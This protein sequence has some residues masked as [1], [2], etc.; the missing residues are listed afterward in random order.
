MSIKDKL[1]NDSS[2]SI[3]NNT[4]IIPSDIFCEV[5]INGKHARLRFLKMK[6]K[7]YIVHSDACDPINPCALDCDF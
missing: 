3:K 5:C 4:I 6:Q 7:N 1:Y 2:H